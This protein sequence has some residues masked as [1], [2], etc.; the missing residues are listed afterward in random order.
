M[1]REVIAWRGFVTHDLEVIAWPT[2]LAEHKDFHRIFGTSD[3]DFAARWRQWSPDRSADI[4]PG[5][6]PEAIQAIDEWLDI[7]R[8]PKP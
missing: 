6:S 8:P 4:D 2:L 7:L 3:E 1:N 5:A